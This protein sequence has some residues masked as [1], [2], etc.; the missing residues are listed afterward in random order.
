MPQDVK[1]IKE[2][3]TRADGRVPMQINFSKQEYNLL[4][5][6]DTMSDNFSQYVKELIIADMK[7]EIT[8]ATLK[9]INKLI[10]DGTIVVTLND[11]QND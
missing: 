7:K 6:V 10:K 5:H 11:K 1:L 8:P 2:R 4:N 9:Y 3:K